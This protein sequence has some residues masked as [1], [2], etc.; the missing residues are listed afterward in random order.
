MQVTPWPCSGGFHVACLV[1]VANYRRS[2]SFTVLL[3]CGRNFKRRRIAIL[4]L[5]AKLKAPTGFLVAKGASDSLCIN[6]PEV[7]VTRTKTNKQTNKQQKAIMV[8]IVVSVSQCIQNGVQWEILT[9][10]LLEFYFKFVNFG[11][12]LIFARYGP[13]MK[14]ILLQLWRISISWSC[15]Q[16]GVINSIV[17]RS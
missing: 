5:P 15:M 1:G 10:V 4:H 13:E 12:C 14:G 11:N 3:R 6:E 2:R 9:S 7:T 16:I 8:I 17:L